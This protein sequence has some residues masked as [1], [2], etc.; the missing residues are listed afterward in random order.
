MFSLLLHW[1]QGNL[2]TTNKLLSY[3]KSNWAASQV[4]STDQDKLYSVLEID[5]SHSLI[6][7]STA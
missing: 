6:T 3:M 7:M 1:E 4:P 5:P 2:G